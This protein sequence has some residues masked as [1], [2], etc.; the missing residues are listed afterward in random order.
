[1][2]GKALA[3]TVAVFACSSSGVSIT[4]P[5][6]PGPWHQLG[7]AATSRLGAKLHISRTA[8]DM[9]ALSFVVTSRSSRRIRVEWATYCEFMSDDDYTESFQGRL[10]GMR[11]VEHYPHVF[12]GATHCDIAVN[13]SAIKGARVTAAVFS[14]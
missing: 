9:K 2:L 4:P 12:D 1:M 8:A 6:Q 7:R 11:R 5:S 13:V 10:S 14:Y 3:T